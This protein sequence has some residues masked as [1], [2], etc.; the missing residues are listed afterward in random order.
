MD[1]SHMKAMKAR[2]KTSHSNRTLTAP[3][4]L[5]LMAITVIAKNR[6]DN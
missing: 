2:E 4:T 1:H 5:V 6:N 3:A